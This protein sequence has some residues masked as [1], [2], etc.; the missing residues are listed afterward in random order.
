MQQVNLG[1]FG[2]STSIQNSPHQELADSVQLPMNSHTR[3]VG[4][5]DHDSGH[6]VNNVNLS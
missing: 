2:R 1:V 4:L 6:H 3:S 5:G